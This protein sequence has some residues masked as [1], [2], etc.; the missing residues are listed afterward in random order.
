M[1]EKSAVDM[2]VR[3]KWTGEEDYG[4]RKKR[5]VRWL[6]AGSGAQAQGLA[7]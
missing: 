5:D 2:T 7:G 1:T 3:A 6:C 4:L